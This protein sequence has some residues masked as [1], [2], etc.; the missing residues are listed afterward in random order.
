MECARIRELLSEYIDGRLSAQTKALLEEHLAACKD[1]REEHAALESLVTELQSLEPMEAPKDFLET[2]H[3]RLEPGFSFG[4]IIRALFVPPR[5]KIPLE[6]A[7]VMAMAVLVFSLLHIQKP[8]EQ[9]AMAPEPASPGK[10][11]KQRALDALQSAPGQEAYQQKFAFKEAASPPPKRKREIIELA[12][13]LKSEAPGRAYAPAAPVEAAKA[14]ESRTG[15]TGQESAYPSK[16]RISRQADVELHEMKRA[17]PGEEKQPMALPKKE[18]LK[19]EG[20]RVRHSLY[21]EEI[22]SEVKNLIGHAEGKVISIEYDKQ[23]ELPYYLNAEIP[24]KQY[25]SLYE[26][27]KQLALIRASPAAMPENDRDVIE[28]RIRFIFQE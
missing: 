19:V 25:S 6:L 15:A 17:E 28:I 4:K 27:L 12:L 1:C 20:E 8:T 16:T 23:A 5:I 9:V 21:A 13:L 11:A 3:E 2:V 10:V 18:K 7:T 14:P 22:L 26:A 24:A